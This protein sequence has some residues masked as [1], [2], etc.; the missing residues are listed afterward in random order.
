MLAD[1]EDE[2]ARLSYAELSERSRDFA[3]YLQEQRMRGERVLIM[4]PQSVDY[5]VAFLGCLYAGAIAVPVFP[6]SGSRNGERV[7]SVVADCQP[8]LAVVTARQEAAIRRQ[9]PE[10]CRTLVP[11]DVLAEGLPPLKPVAPVADDVAYLQYTSGSTS[12]PRG[13]MVTQD[14]LAQ[15]M[16]L[17][18]RAWRLADDEVVVSWLPMFHDFGLVAATMYSLVSG[19]TNV[20]MAPVAFV[21]HP[22]RWLDAIS[23]YR[24][25]VT[26][27]P[28]F[29]LDMSCDRVDDDSLRTLDLTSLRLLVVGAEPVRPRSLRRFT[30]RFGAAGFRADSFNI[31]YGLAEATLAVALSPAGQEPTVTRF[32]PV[33]LGRGR[34][35]EAPDAGEG[36]E[37]PDNGDG[38]LD[39]EL[40]IVDPDTRQ[41]CPDGR[42][43]EIWVAGRTV[44][45]GYWQR[46]DETEA[47]FG[48]QLADGRGRYLRTGDLGARLGGRTYVTGRRK[49]VI[50]IR[51][52]NH[53]P[54]D[55]ELTAA[56]AHPAVATD[57]VVAFAVEID[58][59]ERL[60]L[61]G[62]L[63]RATW[64]TADPD[65]VFTRLQRAVVEA[66]DISVDAM[67]LLRPGQLPLTSSGKVRRR[68][69]RRQ[70]L[71]G[72][73]S[74]VRATWQI[75]EAE[76]S[77]PGQAAGRTSRGRA[78]VVA[79]L[80]RWVA[81][82]RRTDPA[83][84]SVDEPFGGLGLDSAALVR[85]SGELGVELG[86]RLSPQDLYD[87]P[88]VARLA[89]ALTAESAPPAVAPSRPGPTAP[90]DA[91]SVA[92]IGMACRVPGADSV[93]ELWELL[94]GG[95]HAIRAVPAERSALGYRFAEGT[96]V[97]GGFIDGV[98]A[99]DPIFFGI[100]RT[101][102][103]RMD[104]QQRVLL[105]VVWRALEDAGIPTDSLAG[106]RT[107]V[108][109]GISG[110]DYR[111]LQTRAGTVATAYD[112]TG[113]AL[114]VAANR[115][116]HLLDLRGPSQAVDT[117]CSSSLVALH[118]ASVS[119]RRG[120]SDIAIVGGVNLLLDPALTTGFTAAGMLSSEGLCRTFDAAADGYVRGEGCAVVVLR[121]TTDAVRAGDRIRALV[122][123]SA[124]NSDGRSST[125]TAPNGPAQ[126][127]VLRAALT[128]AGVTPG[129][130]GYVEA[131]GTGT[132]LGDP[133]EMGAIRAVYGG[134]A[135]QPLLVGSVKT[136]IGH[137][138]A[139]AGVVGLVKTV[140]CLERG[141]VP[142]SLHFTRLNPYIDLAGS[143]CSVA[144][145]P[146][147]WPGD[148]AQR[149]A[150]VSS[151]G[152]GGT[153]AHVVLSAAPRRAPVSPVGDGQSWSVLPVSAKT[154]DAL[155]Q[156]A[157]RYAELLT[158][159]GLGRT[160]AD[161]AHVAGTRRTRYPHRLAVPARSAGEAADALTRFVDSGTDPLS[162]VAPS[163]PPPVAFVFTGQGSQYAG[164]AAAWYFRYAS[165]R[166]ALDRSDAVVRA[167]LGVSLLPTLCDVPGDRVDLAETQYAQPAVFAVDHALASIW[168]ACGV[169]PSAVLGH[170]LGE[171]VAA[172]VAGVLEL[173][174]ALRL[175]IARARW[176][177]TAPPGAMHAV[178][179][180]PETLAPLLKELA[181]TD[182]VSL[183][184]YNGPEDVVVSGEPGRLAE[185][186]ADWSR[187]G[188]RLTRL[189]GNRA[190]HSP[191]MAE[192]AEEFAETARRVT[193]RPPRIPLI[194]NLTGQLTT[195]VS[196]DTLVRHALSPVRFGDGLATL[197]GLGCRVVVECGSRPVLSPLVERAMPD[198]I[199]LPSLHQGDV[200]D[201][202][203]QR[204]L[205]YWYAHGGDVDWTGLRRARLG[206]DTPEPAPVDLPGH[207]FNP[208]RHWFT[209]Q[210]PE[211]H[212][213]LGRP[214]E[215]AGT[216]QRR[217][218]ATLHPK[219]VLS[220]GQHRLPGGPVL[221]AAAMVEW[222]RSALETGGETTP[223]RLDEV[224]FVAVRPV[225]EGQP[226]ELQATVEPTSDGFTVRCFGRGAGED[227][228]TEHSRL[229]AAPSLGPVA[230]E[231]APE[232][233]GTQWP[234][235]DVA[236]L[237]ARLDQAGLS[238]G[239][240]Y[241]AL[242]RLWRHGDEA[243]GLVELAPSVV[244][245]GYGLHPILLDACLHV[246]GAFVGPDTPLMLPAAIQ[247][248]EV[249][250]RLPAAV[251]CRARW[252]GFD[253]GGAARVDLTVRHP[254]GTL[255]VT[256][257][258][259]VLRPISERPGRRIPERYDITWQPVASVGGKASI[260]A[261]PVDAE[262]AAASGTW[263]VAG[264]D[265]DVVRTWGTQLRALGGD[266]TGLVLNADG[267]A[268]LDGEPADEATAS[269]VS[270]LAER[271]RAR[272]GRV[273]GVIL[274][275]D[276]A[277]LPGDEPERT[278]ELADRTFLFVRAVLTELAADQPRLVLCSV[279]ATGPIG[280][281]AP[282]L[283]GTAV[284]ALAR[285]VVVEY[286][287]LA[288]VHVD[289]P[290]A[291][292]VPAVTTVLALLGDGESG[293]L[294]Q[295]DGR[296]YRAAL[297]R[298]PLPDHAPVRLR[299]DATYLIIG[300]L[301]GLGLATA[302]RFA[303]WGARCLVLA[304]RTLPAAVPPEVER[305]RRA[306]VR[307]ELRR[308]D[309]ADGPAVVALLDEV[310]R[311]LP[312]V[313]GVLH[314]AGSTA[315]A[316]LAEMATDRFHSVLPAKVRG[317]WNLHLAT[318]E[319]PLD[320]FVTFSSFAAVTGSVGQ[321]NYVVANAFLD[322]LARWRQA[323][324]L[325]ALSIGW[326][327]WRE[328]G[329]A[330][331]ADVLTS[332]ADR[333][334]GAL[335][336]ADALR[337]LDALLGAADAPTVAVASVDW[338]RFVGA[339]GHPGRDTLLAELAPA[340]SAT[341]TGQEPLGPGTAAVVRQQLA[342]L[343][344][345]QPGAARDAV[346]AALLDL[347]AEL[348]GMSERDRAD[349]RPTFPATRLN[350]LGLD[351][352][353]AVRLR[354]RLRADFA[355]DVP[356]RLLLG[357]G[358]VAEVAGL[359]C[360]QIVV[361]HVMTL[362]DESTGAEDGD[363]EVLTL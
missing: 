216:R 346:L 176:M 151:F 350:S 67:V 167:E 187:R 95:Q 145:E 73:L 18:A 90:A 299:V 352:L 35:F 199:C 284:A 288:C 166:A 262:V 289:L 9:L 127:A 334:V 348:V 132:P 159:P 211:H 277:D 192:G 49:D 104:P 208:G 339:T 276:G 362:A 181:E 72:E 236:A 56:D 317:S 197:A 305:L 279:G 344:V 68:E 28:N 91:T 103:D 315:D 156:T 213:L 343:A 266:V 354:N 263:L 86:I 357:G 148:A 85:L 223:W 26:F 129:Q 171:Y 97:H 158:D 110:T 360:R 32:D 149:A 228:W 202:R 150:A 93:E 332:L 282:D 313:R 14:A 116:S 27:G 17:L 120:E 140:L 258:G 293:H 146:T 77:V 39:T 54:Q 278:E 214:V 345:E 342:Q 280:P 61:V 179:G 253:D 177:Q 29:A 174:D 310:R 238:Y 189:T 60:A 260:G 168:Q 265:A 81:A 154:R 128:D 325:P 331:R 70:Y 184:A 21:Q 1:G 220:L 36:R 209:T 161:V 217:F 311:T 261:V 138:E 83:T 75:R 358:S 64:T 233:P 337:A 82:A 44:A 349:L 300:G 92:V 63:T 330:A 42:I 247:R 147:R 363:V 121:R 355:T 302:C 328:R 8:A 205:A 301:G 292:P 245:D 244:D 264:V 274:H 267:R 312:P 71:A 324:G 45:A 107:G 142:P 340:A 131:H 115:I 255:L 22:F 201:E 250:G 84:I 186:A 125:L 195:A 31:G 361:R 237:Y 111:Q 281:V 232:H 271:V 241:R 2:V 20:M 225:P 252:H 15:Q 34:L 80:V 231:A 117:A 69:C 268:R 307:V 88:T 272:Q 25:A 130:V 137:L 38:L 204:G 329:L 219:A 196:A 221:P 308:L 239:P 249:A 319:D 309:V 257:T 321:A 99:F 7:S 259:L 285:S 16:R 341:P 3:R 212:P 89:G 275:A 76:P 43:G 100:S 226:V 12:T 24:A 112:G 198:A 235:Q 254:D 256:V 183:A 234:E 65:E 51:G 224:E 48:G 323:R 105:G 294:A 230:D 353:M 96:V 62:E 101:E 58:G 4:L 188:A 108:F 157:R 291:G 40:L 94:A 52:V 57:R 356:P 207:P 200:D 6:P 290:Q 126:E 66:H 295:R 162:G 11:A 144:T 297:V 320:L 134:P 347:V 165:F 229:R 246:V 303:S 175:V 5:V 46:A 170:S 210:S 180:S 19:A 114:T 298:S 338:S 123:G 322:G 203:F 182:E 13:V 47:V 87:H 287:D 178:H 306:G 153:N 351:S 243:L 296:W 172:C 37:L 139:A 326:G 124:V 359:I 206:P 102:A 164:M 163:V 336:D 227:S 248:L 53:Y 327:P 33:E 59:V 109:V 10:S 133:I 191:L 136:N 169:H 55:V 222:A 273:A 283:P 98:D 314:A 316:L 30:A 215:L 173:S 304:G 118:A 193:F 242:R 113:N 122:R 333:G 143:R 119:L 141:L 240:D 135:S 270:R 335:D 74:G 50:I 286:P 152:F 79:W 269:T 185:L 41:P 106:S 23:R 190:F 78:D 318:T 155:R 218:A 251:W 160:L 194:A